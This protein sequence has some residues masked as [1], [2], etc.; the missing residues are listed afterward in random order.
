MWLG[1]NPKSIPMFKFSFPSKMIEKIKEEKVI[2]G[3][4]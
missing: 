3:E 4:K 1:I 2:V